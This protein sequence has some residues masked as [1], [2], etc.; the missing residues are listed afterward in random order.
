MTAY[1]KRK[2]A[3]ERHENNEKDQGGRGRAFEL[4]CA[5]KLSQKTKVAEQNENDCSVKMRLNNGKIAYIPTECKTN[6]GRIDEILVD[7]PRAKL[8]IYR[9]EYTQKLKNSVDVRKLPP[10]IAPVALF[11][12]MLRRVNAIKAINKQGVFSGYGIQASSKKMYEALANYIDNYGEAILFDN[13]RTYE[14]WD[15]EGLEL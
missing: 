1:E 3:I 15:F 11:V 14:E 9:L 12:D 6:G 4:Q 10:I 7:T 13:E 2:I 5:R 8:I